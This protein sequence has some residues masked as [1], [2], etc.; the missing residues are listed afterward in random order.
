MLDETI[1]DTT[2]KDTASEE[3]AKPT[4]RDNPRSPDE[5]PEEGAEG[6]PAP[7]EL[8]AEELRELGVWE[9]DNDT[10]PETET[11]TET[12]EHQPTPCPPASTEKAN[13]KI[14][15]Y[16]IVISNAPVDNEDSEPESTEADWTDC[17]SQRSGRPS[18]LPTIGSHT[19]VCKDLAT[20]RA[21]DYLM[22]GKEALESSRTL[23]RELRATAVE[24]LSNLYELVLSLADS[25]HR[26]RL[27]LETERTRAARELVLTERAHR[28]EIQSMRTEFA[29]RLQETKEALSGTER[30]VTGVQSWLNFEMD[31]L[32]K[33]V[34]AIHLEVQEPRKPAAAVTNAET[35]NPTKSDHPATDHSAALADISQKLGDLANEVHYLQQCNKDDR[36]E[37]RS[38][39][40]IKTEPNT[41]ITARVESSLKELREDT[42]SMREEMSSLKIDILHPKPATRAEIRQELKEATDPLVSKARSIQK[43][44][45]EVRDIALSSGGVPTTMSLGPE[46]AIS[47]TAAQ[48]EGLINPLRADV[49]E[50]ANTSKALNKTMEWYNSAIKKQ[51]E[52]A[53]TAA[54][55][56]TYAQATRTP[57]PPKPNHTLIVSATNPNQTGENVIDTIRRT[58]D[59]KNTGLT[60]DRVRKAKNSKVVLSCD[61]KEN[62]R[63]LQQRIKTNKSLKVQ[64]AKAANPLI[65]IKGVMAYHSDDEIV[66]HLRAQNQ[67]LFV[68]LEGDEKSLRVRYRKRARNALQ[69]HPVLE[70]SPL[71][72]RRVLELGTVHIGLEKRQV[73]DQS[74]LVQCAKCLG[75]GH[76][77]SLCRESHQLCNYCGGMHSWQDCQTRAQGGQPKCKNCTRAK[78]TESTEPHVAFSDECPEKQ[79]WDRIARSKIAYC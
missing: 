16:S 66:E 3:D 56:K 47:E 27:S 34:K 72:H 50:M 22:L 24:C 41:E 79:T 51:R 21:R 71:L 64:E 48:I 54:E 52:R 13:P 76:T 36:R 7:L 70:V 28:K 19:G 68:G 5:T 65:R 10:L 6:G 38:P 33:T 55:P 42:K 74:P 60:V 29:E 67:K 17:E 40:P 1:N 39:T 15:H 62:A 58:L 26:H 49:A 14:D 78:I 18:I 61:T 23:K 25:R 57:P 12:A 32:I 8:T 11:A 75:F 73:E 45:E 46:I 37:Y 20:D 63:L 53:P 4:G 35:A 31:G 59:M 43:G 44:I 30:A 9:H 69:C 77:K 2:N